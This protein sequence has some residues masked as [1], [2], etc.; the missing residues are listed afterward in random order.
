MR[1]VM[2]AGLFGRAQAFMSGAAAEMQRKL[3]VAGAARVEDVLAAPKWPLEWPYTPRDFG[4]GDT[5]N[6]A[7]F[8]SQ[9]RFCFHVDDKAIEALTKYYGEAF[10][11][12]DKPDVLDICASHV[13]HFPKDI[14]LGNAVALGMNEDELKENKQV[15]SYVVR[16]LN[17]DPT[18][19]FPDN[20]FDI[21]TNVVSI[22][23]LT[24]P[25]A[26]C[27]EVARVLKP[28]GAAIF[29]LSNRCFP[30][31]AVDIWLRTNDL[32]HAFVVGSYFHY[33]GK[34]QPPQALEVS[35]NKEKTPWQGGTSQ[36]VA[37]LAIVRATVDK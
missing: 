31:K 33:T 11:A 25:A 3:S 28:G 35:P 34:F 15:D 7:N 22:D 18:L 13:S 32:E 23:Y 5:S 12:W 21:V 17:E 8:Y 19:P 9:P 30:S 20:S 2:L 37:Y 36:N 16:D 27:A 29:A 26:I 24:K 6:D 4:R 10:T 1:T 14:Q